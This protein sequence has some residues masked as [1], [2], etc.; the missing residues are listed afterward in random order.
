VARLTAAIERAGAAQAM[1]VGLGV[2]PAHVSAQALTGV[3]P[4]DRA[5]L[6]AGVLARTALVRLLLEDGEA[7]A[8]AREASFRPLTPA[9]VSRFKARYAQ[10]DALAHRAQGLLATLVPARLERAGREVSARWLSSLAPLEP[11]LVRSAR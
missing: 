1:L 9:E 5:A 4:G 3:E 11:V 2:R 8:A 6:D 10:S 7:D